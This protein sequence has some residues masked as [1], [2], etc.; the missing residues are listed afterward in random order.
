MMAKIKDAEHS[1]SIAEMRQKIAQLEIEVCRKGLE[2][3]ELWERERKITLYYL[4]AYVN[5]QYCSRYFRMFIS[6]VTCF[7]RYQFH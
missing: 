5:A 7:M 1:Q 3:R 2:G 6:L 4:I